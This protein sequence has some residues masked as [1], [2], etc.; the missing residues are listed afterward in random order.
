[1]QIK[2][3]KFVI[4][5]LRK[6]IPII[7]QTTELELV[8]DYTIIYDVTIM[9]I[10]GPFQFFRM[11]LLCHIDFCLSEHIT[12]FCYMWQHSD[13]VIILG[14]S[15]LV[16]L[17]TWIVAVRSIAQGH[18]HTSC[19]ALQL[20]GLVWNVQS[21]LEFPWTLD[22]CLSESLPLTFPLGIMP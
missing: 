18:Y 11:C 13:I 14:P 12:M 22:I 16:N 2:I 21:K 17:R 9:L 7:L 4:I 5:L 19:S 1:M 6:T 20:A 10:S 3:L 8:F 15:F